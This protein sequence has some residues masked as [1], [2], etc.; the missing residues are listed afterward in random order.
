MTLP[1]QTSEC[2]ANVCRDC[3]V[4]QQA[5]DEIIR[6]GLTKKQEVREHA[7]WTVTNRCPYGVEWTDTL[8]PAKPVSQT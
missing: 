3:T 2:P 5:Q 1:N 4:Y 7:Q 8:R 6:R